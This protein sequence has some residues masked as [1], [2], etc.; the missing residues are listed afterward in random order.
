[1]RTIVSLLVKMFVWVLMMLPLAHAAT[2]PDFATVRAETTTTEGRLV[3]RAGE[4]LAERRVSFDGRRLAWVPLDQLSPALLEAL[5]EAED[6]RFYQHDGVDW[7]AFAAAAVQ[8]L[9]F[10]HARGASTLTMQLAG[11]LDPALRPGAGVHG[12]RT[13]EQKFDQAVAAQELDARWSKAEILEAY[14]NLVPFRGELIGIHAAAWALFEKHPSELDRTQ[15]ALLAALLRAPNASPAKV[16]WRACALL[17]RIGSEDQCDRAKALAA[18]FDPIRLEPRWQEAPQLAR[19]LVHA[20]GEVVHTV[21][22]AAWQR[23][24]HAALDGA[25]PG[26]GAVVVIDN[27]TGAVLADVGGVAPAHE[28]ATIVRR[29]LGALARPVITAL[30]IDSKTV[31]AATLVRNSAAEDAHSVRWWLAQGRW[32][33]AMMQH[34]PSARRDLLIELLRGPG[35]GLRTLP[36]ARIDLAAL[37]AWHRMMAVD[38][39]WRPPYWLASDQRAPIPVCSPMAAFIADELY[40]EIWSAELEPGKAAW[41]VG[42]NDSVTIAVYLSL[43]PA[44][45]IEARSWVEAQLQASGTWPRERVVPTGVVQGLVRFD[46]PV[47]PDR[48]EWFVRGTAMSVAEPPRI[49]ASI[50]SPLERAIIGRDDLHDGMLPLKADREDSR[51]RWWIDGVQVGTGARALWRPAPGLHQLQLKDEAGR[52]LAGHSIAVRAGVGRTGSDQAQDQPGQQ[53]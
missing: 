2:I 23:R 51:L 28:D 37:A 11:M 12:R 18:G 49:V 48:L 17:R 45:R 1:M 31:T 24:M 52:L 7:R 29:P 36:E 27:A 25:A 39:L 8:N 53:R 50:V 14:L 6:R 16:A 34:V 30:A 35:E 9:W 13:L 3:D 20:P 22:E 32:P 15:A 26:R 19:R 46:P 21:L 4:P 5:I 40:P 42:S 41:A 43:G 10:E 44:A 47:E 33:A 38:G